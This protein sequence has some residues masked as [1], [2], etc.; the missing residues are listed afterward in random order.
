M[1]YG[2]LS[3]WRGLTPGCAVT[4]GHDVRRVERIEL[5]ERGGS[6]VVHLALLG[7]Y[8]ERQRVSAYLWRRA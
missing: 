6:V 8:G 1:T 5:V 4:R 2:T 3:A 7:P